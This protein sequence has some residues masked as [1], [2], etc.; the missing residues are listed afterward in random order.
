MDRVE[1]CPTGARL[2]GD[3]KNPDDPVTKLFEERQWLVLKPEMY[4]SPMCLYVE[5]PKEVV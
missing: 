1:A 4:T 5:L 3:L 2:F